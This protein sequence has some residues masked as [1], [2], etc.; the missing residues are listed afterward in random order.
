MNFQRHLNDNCVTGMRLNMLRNSPRVVQNSR[1]RAIAHYFFCNNV[2]IYLNSETSM[3][4][5]KFLPA[6]SLGLLINLFPVAH[7]AQA[8]DRFDPATGILSIPLVQVGD[9][10]YQDVQ[11]RIFEQD[12]VSVGSAKGLLSYDTFAG[13]S[14]ELT[15]GSVAVGSSIYRNVVVKLNASNLIAATLVRQDAAL[16][17]RIDDFMRPYLTAN[18]I[19]AATLTLMKDDKVL[20]E[21]AYGYQDVARSIPLRSNALLTTASIV[22]PVTAA[23]AQNLIA[24]GKLQSSD[25]VFCG[26]GISPS[27]AAHCWID[28]NWVTASDA[29]IQQITISHLLSHSGGWD[30][31][32]TSCVAFQA[33][34]ATT[35]AALVASGNPCDVLQ[36]EFIV[37]AV[38]G[39]AT[40]PSQEQLIRFVMQG[41]LD[42][43]PGTTPLTG[44]RYSNFGYVL[45]GLIVERASG[46][47]YIEFVTQN[48]LGPLG[49]ATSDFK[50]ARSL[51]SQAD[52]REPNYVTSK[53]YPSV[54][55]PGTM[56]PA[57]NGALNAENF[58]AAA[59]VITTSRT[60]A[61]FAGHYRIDTDSRGIDGPE[62][63]TPLS[64]IRK[65]GS[66]NGA[67]PGTATVVTQLPSGVS[68]AVLLNKNDQFEGE[69]QRK[70]YATEVAAGIEAALRAS[71]YQE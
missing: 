21:T 65:Y 26:P 44:D 70:D 46:M 1:P 17:Q 11:I 30:R 42:F 29:R 64:G 50:G 19:S 4:F 45:L 39:I 27:A 32:G 28:S 56:V 61:R 35:R 59:T 69:G 67:L 7:S 36:H 47:P 22:K 25:R 57:R 2:G 62:N 8:M 43:T 51:L 20:Y 66:H 58:F 12:V 54:F 40:P 52:P 13:E 10:F 60:M 38:L 3:P 16:G 6:A 33:A 63:G 14:A 41:N 37:Q 55:A 15:I 31:A 71:G 68:F 24:Q 49:V 23:A 53:Q 48:V 34:D 18:G 5:S 9:E